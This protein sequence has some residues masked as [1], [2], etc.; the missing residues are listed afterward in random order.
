MKH[1]YTA[2]LLALAVLSSAVIVQASKHPIVWKSAKLVSFGAQQGT[3]TY[4][5]QTNGKVN[6]NGTYS[7]TTT[8]SNWSYVDYQVVLDDGKMLYYGGWTLEFRWQH[9]PSFTENEMVQYDLDGNKLTVV[10][11][12]GKKIK[13]KLIKRRIKE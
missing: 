13:M 6:G 8:E 1:F 5:A 4:S 9:D 3:D 7:A 10:D 11:D 2:F 12:A